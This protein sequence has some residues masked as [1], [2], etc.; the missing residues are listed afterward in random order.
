MVTVHT[1]IYR[2]V[3]LLEIQHVIY[4]H[5]AMPILAQARWEN[6]PLSTCTYSSLPFSAEIN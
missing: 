5:V 1:V 4:N 2:G 6:V 3:I